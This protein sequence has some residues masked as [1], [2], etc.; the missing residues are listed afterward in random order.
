MKFQKIISFFIL[1]IFASFSLFLSSCEEEQTHGPEEHFEPYGLQLRDASRKIHLKVFNGEID[2]QYNDE[3]EVALDSLSE[4]YDLEFLDK[5]GKIITPPTAAEYNLKFNFD[6]NTLAEV[7][8]HDGNKWKIH[9]KGLKL[10]V[11]N[12]EITF[13][14]NE[15]VDFRTP[16]IKFHVRNAN[17]F[18]LFQ[19]KI[20]NNNTN[21]V[22]VSVIDGV[23]T[24]SL[25]LEVGKSLDITTKV[26]NFKGDLI[27]IDNI[28][29]TMSFDYH[30]STN[31]CDFDNT[32]IN[33]Q[34]LI[35]SSTKK[36]NSKI[37]IRLDQKIEGQTVTSR[38]NAIG[39]NIN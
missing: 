11:T 4:G 15:H 34:R 10:G 31:L 17:N 20:Y 27:A 23:V 1:A 7:H 9:F 18:D 3:I 30:N 39:L 37:Y 32:H 35:L 24:G 25:D 26:Y 8:G 38:T 6:D 16:K 19:L 29:Y 33:S 2:K 36:G 13:N 22:I 28:N 5:D 21:E 12:L 14:H